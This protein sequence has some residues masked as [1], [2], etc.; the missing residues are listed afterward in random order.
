[1]CYSFGSGQPPADPHEDLEGTRLAGRTVRTDD[2][3]RR[4]RQFVNIPGSLAHPLKKSPDVGVLRY[5]DGAGSGVPSTL[6]GKYR[7][8]PRQSII[9][10]R[11][12]ISHGFSLRSG[13][14]ARE[15]GCAAPVENL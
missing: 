14:D 7:A 1:M 5:G 9:D 10:A 8:L 12:G 13:E 11:A 6:N 15:D 3:R 2:P 4:S